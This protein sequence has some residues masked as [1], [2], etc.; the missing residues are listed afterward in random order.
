LFDDEDD[1]TYNL[2]KPREE[3]EKKQMN[4]IKSWSRN[5]LVRRRRP[6]IAQLTE[7]T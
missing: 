6:R 7:A 1:G 2:N 3:T 5:S 4:N